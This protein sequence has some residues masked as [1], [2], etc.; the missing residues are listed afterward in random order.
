MVIDNIENTYAPLIK[1]LMA[2][3][4]KVIIDDYIMRS[5]PGEQIPDQMFELFDL[6]NHVSNFDSLQQRK[7]DIYDLK[8]IVKMDKV[9]D[10]FKNLD[11]SD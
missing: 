10:I 2:E 3:N 1:I 8:W 11:I 6:A 4:L 5:K 9:I 7:K